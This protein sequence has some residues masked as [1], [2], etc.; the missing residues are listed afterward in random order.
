M[1]PMTIHRR[2]P[3]RAV[4]RRADERGDH[5]ERRHR[6]RQV[7]EDLPARVVRVEVEEERAGQGDRDQGIARRHQHMGARQ[8][9]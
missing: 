7:E 2:P 9:R 6:E 5:R 1:T 4:E 3:T 8:P